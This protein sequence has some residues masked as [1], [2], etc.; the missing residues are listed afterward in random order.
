MAH[1]HPEVLHLKKAAELLMFLNGML[2]SAFNV[3]NA[4]LFALTLL[5]A[6]YL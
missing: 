5:F 3:T 1:S 6:L 2:T 4:H